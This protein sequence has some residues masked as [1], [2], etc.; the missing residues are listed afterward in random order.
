V[1]DIIRHIRGSYV[2]QIKRV[3]PKVDKYTYYTIG[4]VI[5]ASGRNCCGDGSIAIPN[6]III[7]VM[8]IQSVDCG[9]TVLFGVHNVW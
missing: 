9:K 2:V 5:L 6:D 1:F 4:D 8:P 3:N 7:F